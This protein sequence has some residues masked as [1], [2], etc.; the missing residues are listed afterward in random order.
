MFS[1]VERHGRLPG[2]RAALILLAVTASMVGAACGSGSSASSSSNG[3]ASSRAT[4]AATTASSSAAAATSSATST[5]SP[6]PDYLKILAPPSVP[7]AT[8][9]WKIIFLDASTVLPQQKSIEVGAQAAAKKYGIDLT[10][11]DAGGFQNL[12]T[13][14]GQFQ[15]ALGDN[16][17][18]ILILPASPVAFN[19]E[20]KQAEQ[21]K[22]KV[23]PLLIPPPSIKFDYA[24]ADD[25][26]LDAAKSVDSLATALHGK[27]QV[28]AIIGG[29]GSS[30]AELFTQGMNQ[31]LKKYPNLKLVVSRTLPGYTPSDAQTAA[32]DAITSHPGIDGILTNDT[33]L[34]V[35]AAKAL[36]LENK[37]APIAGIGPGD[38]AT[39]DA[40]KSGEITMG[41]GPPFYAVGYDTVLWADYLLAGHTAPEMVRT[42]TPAVVTKDNINQAI[43]SGG[44]FQ[45]LAPTAVGCGPGESSQC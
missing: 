28:M 44:L 5:A 7:R 3:S 22:I 21:K 42:V 16:P 17:N 29:A 35:G 38:L 13:Q 39:I 36:K 4:T 12:T 24:L 8:K 1:A 2:P 45:I 31:E 9:P 34:G 25:L 10:V 19:S 40:L 30:V 33:I 6:F 37:T 32:Q 14:V 27:G 41:S 18:A 11:L 26:P 43:S 20:I 15:T 23:L